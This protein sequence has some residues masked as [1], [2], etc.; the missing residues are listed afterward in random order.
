MLW[1]APPHPPHPEVDLSQ[2]SS[3]LENLKGYI[4]DM[5]RTGMHGSEELMP[6]APLLWSL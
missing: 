2:F 5:E 4:N 1:A 6:S 3:D